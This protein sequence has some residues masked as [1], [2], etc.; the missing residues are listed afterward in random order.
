ME[1]RLRRREK[2]T[3]TTTTTAAAAATTT[4]K[5]PGKQNGHKNIKVNSCEDHFSILQVN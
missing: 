4:T 2:T 1:G 5:Q 3:T